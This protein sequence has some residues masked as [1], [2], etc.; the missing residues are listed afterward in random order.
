[1]RKKPEILIFDP[2][3]KVFETRSRQILLAGSW[4]TALPKTDRLMG[5]PPEEALR[6]LAGY[7]RDGICVLAEK[8]AE[9][10]VVELFAYRGPSTGCELFFASTP[11]GRFVLSDSFRKTAES[12][13]PESRVPSREGFLDFL[14]FQNSPLPETPIASI[15]RLGHGD[16]LRVDR[17]GAVDERPF[18]R[19][20]FRG[21]AGSFREGVERIEE[22]LSGALGRLPNEGTNLLSGGV[23][24]TLVQV[25]LGPGYQAAAAAIDSPEFAFE[26]ENARRSASLCGVSLQERPLRENDLPDRIERESAL[27]GIPLPLPQVAVIASVFDLK[28]FFFA[29]GFDAD[30]LFSLPRPKRR[31]ALD[32]ASLQSFE[33]R[34]FS[35]SPEP[36]LLE[37]LFCREE[38][39]DR[40]ARRE[41]YVRSRIAEPDLLVEL[42]LG[43][44]TSLY[45]S[46]FS[47]YRHLAAEREKSF[48]T[49]FMDRQVVEAALGLPATERLFREG[50]F[51][52]VL[53]D[54]LSRRLPSFPENLEK[55]GS[56]LPRTRLCRQGPL[57]GFFRKNP[58]PRFIDGKKADPILN[59][60]WE[61]SMTTYRC[62]AWSVWE[63][64][65]KAIPGRR[66][67]WA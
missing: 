25:L 23:D 22:A 29:S 8:D 21:R 32:G 66:D 10:N 44:L 20:S 13:P 33:A 27:A 65:V 57:R 41:A 43:C 26:T 11:D 28:G 60:T 47:V 19:L 24:S 52:P 30:S 3:K 48:F 36:D 6:L 49:P 55:G 7:E 50:V 62:I 18:E 42:E 45:C 34:S 40:T 15:R 16:L 37:T 51:K 58:L 35:L 39:A 1:M 31:L 54:I 38:I 4:E 2:G 14:L 59:P 64:A 53:K 46:S 56:G 12:L 61:S 5:L 9:E 17:D 63:Q 67:Q